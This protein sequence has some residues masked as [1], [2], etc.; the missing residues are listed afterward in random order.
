MLPNCQVDIARFHRP[1]FHV[2]EIQE[3]G[4][5]MGLK[6]ILHVNFY[7]HEEMGFVALFPTQQL[8]LPTA[9]SEQHSIQQ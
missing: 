5:L 4:A 9:Q 2:I 8:H 6:I 3:I 1:R 7:R